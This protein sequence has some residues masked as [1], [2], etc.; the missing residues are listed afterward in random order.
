MSGSW[1][2]LKCAQAA[3]KTFEAEVSQ[4]ISNQGFVKKSF[5][6]GYAEFLQAY[7]PGSA[8]AFYDDD[9]DDDEESVAR[10]YSPNYALP[11]RSDYRFMIY[12][13]IVPEEILLVLTAALLMA[14]I[15]LWLFL[16]HDC[17]PICMVLMPIDRH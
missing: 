9:D 6:L 11:P 7:S 1:G 10:A 17:S 8:N 16:A 14:Q 4:G 15:Q 12:S 2:P 3:Q 13:K 5:F